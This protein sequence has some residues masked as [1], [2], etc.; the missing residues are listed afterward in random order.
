[1]WDII[2]YVE[3]EV[4][5]LIRKGGVYY[6]LN[7]PWQTPSPVP[8]LL[9]SPKAEAIKI[10]DQELFEQ[11]RIRALAHA[12]NHTCA[13]SRGGLLGK[14]AE[15]ISDLVRESLKFALRRRKADLVNAQDFIQMLM[16]CAILEPIPDGFWKACSGFMSE[17]AS[18]KLKTS[19][20][21]L[22]AL[23]PK[24][25]G[26]IKSLTSYLQRVKWVQNEF[27]LIQTVARQL[28]F[29]FREHECGPILNDLR[30]Q[31][32]NLIQREEIEK[33]MASQKPWQKNAIPVK[34]AIKIGPASSNTR[35]TAPKDDDSGAKS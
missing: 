31:A 1:M 25:N 14:T 21:A 9:A 2:G 28:A 4:S 20:E 10:T 8:L 16:S 23:Q 17:D 32:S 15:G 11:L 24:D 18:S 22:Y 27:L 34:R 26:W 13:L 19:L 33:D 5:L 12:L 35:K 6:V 7:Y 30:I 3:K 29:T